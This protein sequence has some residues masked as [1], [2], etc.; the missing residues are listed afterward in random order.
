MLIT[1][2]FYYYLV[3]YQ[4]LTYL[5]NCSCLKVW[6]TLVLFWINFYQSIKYQNDHFLCTWLQSIKLSLTA[7]KVSV[8]G[9]FLVSIFL[10]SEWIRRD[11]EWPEKLRTWTLFTQCLP[12]QNSCGTRN[13]RTTKIFV[14]FHQI[15]LMINKW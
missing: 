9:V 8:F 14:L 11:T 2:R 15:H 12:K 1:E 3:Q 10:H 6:N 4:K 13:I 7:W 5:R